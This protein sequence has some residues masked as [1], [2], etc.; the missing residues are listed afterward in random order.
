M[1]IELPQWAKETRLNLGLENGE[2]SDEEGILARL[3]E[4]WQ[5]LRE[6]QCTAVE[7]H[8]DY[9]C[10]RAEAKALSNNT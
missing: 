2:G 6:V 7:R 5:D 8:K 10:D 9:L 3:L 4:A 1:H